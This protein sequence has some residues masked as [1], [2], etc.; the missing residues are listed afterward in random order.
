MTPMA[1]LI[2]RLNDAIEQR[3]WG[4]RRHFPFVLRLR[5]LQKEDL[6]Q[7]LDAY[8]PYLLDHVF[9]PRPLLQDLMERA[10]NGPDGEAH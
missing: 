7:I 4:I 8:A 3:G 1:K 5:H 2:K 10:S 6:K 9:Q